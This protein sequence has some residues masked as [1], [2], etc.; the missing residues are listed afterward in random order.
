MLLWQLLFGSTAHFIINVFGAFTFLAAGLLYFD[1]SHADK[2]N[3][4]ILFRSAGFFLLAT[5]IILNASTIPLEIITVFAQTI[6]NIGLLLIL[7]SLMSEPVLHK[8]SRKKTAALAGVATLTTVTWATTPFSAILFLLIA[9][10]YLRKATEGMEKQLKGAGVAF[11]LLAGAEAFQIPLYWAD[12]PVIFWSKIFAEF[13]IVWSIQRFLQFAGILVFAVWIW[14]YIRFQLRVQLLVS[15]M[16]L[17]LVVFVTAT[18]FYTFMLLRNMEADA[19]SHLATDVQVL[20]Y[21][22]DALKAK[23]LAHAQAVAQDS[24]V[25]DALQANDSEK[26]YMLSSDYIIAQQTEAKIYS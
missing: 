6:K 20:A 11:L 4:T 8:P 22:L 12:T 14:G 9:V 15:T 25:K 23:T 10:T 19:L 16:G 24:S 17:S 1:A 21:S 5:T 2:L 3:R 18:V 13:G 7:I 26:L